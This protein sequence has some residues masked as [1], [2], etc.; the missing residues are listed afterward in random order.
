MTYLFK[1]IV[2]VLTISPPHPYKIQKHFSAKS[3]SGK[4]FTGDFNFRIKNF[5]FEMNYFS[6]FSETFI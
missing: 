2:C 4:V 5:I 1:K 3:F 6:D